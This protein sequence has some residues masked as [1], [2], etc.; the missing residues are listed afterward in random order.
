MENYRQKLSILGDKI[1]QTPIDTCESM[2]IPRSFS[3]LNSLWPLF[4]LV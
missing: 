4:L 1:S 2:E 3:F